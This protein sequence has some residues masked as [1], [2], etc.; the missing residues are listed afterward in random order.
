MVGTIFE[1]LFG[2]PHRRMTRPITPVTKPGVPSGGTYVVCLDCGKQFAYDWDQMRIGKPIERA[3]DSGVL[4]PDMPSAS[5]AKIK[6]A[7]LGSA[8]PLAVLLGNLLRTKRRNKSE[9]SAPPKAGV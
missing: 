6:Y 4:R 7:L 8:L 1:R 2:C 3:V 9:T 5:K